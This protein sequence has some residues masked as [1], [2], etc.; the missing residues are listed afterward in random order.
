MLELSLT[1]GGTVKTAIVNGFGDVL[2]T[3][4]FGACKIGD[5][6]SYLEDA[7]IGSCRKV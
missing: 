3:D 1:P 5:S 4:L 6:T 7:V 2:L